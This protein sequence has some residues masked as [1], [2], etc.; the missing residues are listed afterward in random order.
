MHSAPGGARRNRLPVRRNFCDA[1]WSSYR[2]HPCR[3]V[4]RRH[5]L[6]MER[7]RGF[8]LRTTCVQLTDDAAVHAIP[9]G[10][11][12]WQTIGERTE[13]QAG[14]LLT[15]S[16]NLE[17]WP[18]WERHPGGDEIAYALSGAFEFIFDDGERC[19]SVLL[20]RGSACIVPQNIWHRAIV[21]E[22]GDILFVTRGAGTEHRPHV[23]TV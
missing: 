1:L 13:L 20:E 3:I 10:D 19:H 2:R 22:P 17:S 15:V 23:D 21:N 18:F 14:R 4:A 7:K 11:D 12:F 16:R 6:T 9:V 8:D 5:A